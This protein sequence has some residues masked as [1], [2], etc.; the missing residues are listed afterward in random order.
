MS[1]GKVDLS[2]VTTVYFARTKG[3]LATSSDICFEEY[4]G[5]AWVSNGLIIAV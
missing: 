3:L 1:I 2:S 5:R 4:T